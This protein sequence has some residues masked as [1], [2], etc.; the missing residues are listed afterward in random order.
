MRSQFLITCTSVESCLN[1]F[2]TWQLSSPEQVIKERQK[3]KPSIFHNISSKVRQCNFLNI[4]LFAQI[5]PN[6][7]GKGIQRAGFPLSEDH[8]GLSWRL[9]SMTHHPYRNLPKF[10]WEIL[11]YNILQNWDFEVYQD[12]IA[13]MPEYLPP[14]LHSS[15]LSW[16]QDLNLLTFLS[17]THVRPRDLAGK[18][19]EIHI[20]E[21]ESY[22]HTKKYMPPFQANVAV[23]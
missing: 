13:G 22:Q 19:R 2:N 18:V 4:L 11:R 16:P 1:I 5:I 10:Y 14:I 21:A 12:R 23:D 6:Q 7:Y 9:A 8:W 3:L 17:C 15:F 20:L